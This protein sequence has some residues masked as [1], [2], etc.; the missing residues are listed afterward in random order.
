MRDERELFE[1]DRTLERVS[2][3]VDGAPQQEHDAS[4]AF[5]RLDG[6]ISHQR[7]L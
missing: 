2:V 4:I 1:R 3:L 6:P 5:V 7:L